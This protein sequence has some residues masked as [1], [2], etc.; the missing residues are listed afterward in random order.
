M[1]RDLKKDLPSPA[2]KNGP[3]PGGTPPREIHEASASGTVAFVPQG[4]AS[5]D[6]TE[7]AGFVPHDRSLKRAVGEADEQ[8]KTVISQRPVAAPEEFYR[9]MPLSE[10]AGML[11][12]RQLDHFAVDQ[13]IGGGGM[14]AV[15]RGRDLR[16]DRIVAIKVIPASKREPETLRRFRIEAQAAARLDHPNIARVYYVGEAEQWNYIVFEFIDGVNIR[17][18]VEMEGPLSVDDAV[19][20]T[21]QV[22]EALQHA[23][24]RDVVHRDIKPSNVLV[25]AGGMAKVVDMGLARNTA[26]EKSTTDATAS[27]VTLGTFDYISPEQARNPRDADVRSDLYSLGCTLFYMLT[28]H[29]P[30]PEGTALQKLLSHGSQPPPDPRGWREDLSDQLY[31]I[32]MKLMAKRPSDRYQ[33]PAEL[34]SDLIMLAELEDLPRSQ[35]TGTVMVSPNIAQRSLVES[36]LPWMVALAFLLGSVLWLQ[37]VQLSNDFELNNLEYRSSPAEAEAANRAAQHQ[38]PSPPSVEAISILPRELGPSN[39][40]A[41]VEVNSPVVMGDAASAASLYTPASPDNPEAVAP[42]LPSGSSRARGTVVV[43]GDRPLD[44]DPQLWERSLTKALQRAA[45]DASFQVVE[46]RGTSVIDELINVA[47]RELLIRGDASSQGVIEF[48]EELLLASLDGA[49]IIDLV[50]SKLKFADLAFQVRVPRDL[51]S[52]RLSLFRILGNSQLELQ[53]CSVTLVDTRATRTVCIV[54]REPLPPAVEA[55]LEGAR[56]TGEGLPANGNGNGA[57]NGRGTMIRLTDCVVRGEGSLLNSRVTE[58]GVDDRLDV[59]I[60]NTLVA[61]TGS[62]IDVRAPTGDIRALRFANLFCDQSTFV[63]DGPFAV[64]TYAGGASPLLGLKRTSQNSIY[65]SLPGVP[66][67]LINGAQRQS[68]LGNFDLLLFQGLNNLYDENI[69]DLCHCMLKAEKSATF[70]FTESLIAGWF[71][72]R[73]NESRVRWQ[74]ANVPSRP[75][76][77]VSPPEFAVTEV[78]FVP[79]ISPDRLYAPTFE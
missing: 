71:S 69:V 8:E 59:S 51:G 7:G 44:V 34:I 33:K 62:V 39:R 58:M 22:A 18:L 27:G 63:T 72:E 65:W 73:G 78:L 13:M 53:G 77:A 45:E 56:W 32:T 40:D 17:D 28:G 61:M 64:L 11:E 24:E 5:L 16:L 68:L 70:G 37:S 49:G 75:L 20:Y 42:V 15:F 57:A 46:V 48:S 52:K 43:S 19:F 67:V 29:P 38:Q 2:M 30:F 9:S 14:G 12:G 35:A 66:H 50:D 55:S 25:T 26:L 47:P 41:S 36:N 74:A 31:E 6:A 54:A 3:L 60:T 79:G 21:R 23:N 76:H 10:L 4:L 1:E